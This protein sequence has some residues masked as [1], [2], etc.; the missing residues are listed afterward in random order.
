LRLHYPKEKFGA[1]FQKFGA[2]I[3][4]CDFIFFTL[5]KIAKVLERLIGLSNSGRVFSEVKLAL[6]SREFF[7]RKQ[8]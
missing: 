7:P 8:Y 5:L 2:R 6:S 1:R 4:K 3:Q